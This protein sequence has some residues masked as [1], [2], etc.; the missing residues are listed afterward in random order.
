MTGVQTCALPIFITA[1]LV[2]GETEAHLSAITKTGN[3]PIVEASAPDITVGTMLRVGEALPTTPLVDQ[4]GATT[5]L[6]RLKG[7]RVVLTFIYTRCPD[8]EFCPLMDRN[9]V[10][11]QTALAQTPALADVRLLSISFDPEHDTPE[12]LRAHAQSLK[13]D[14]K[15]WSF[16]APAPADLK[17]FAAKFG[18]TAEPGAANQGAILHNLSTA[19]VAADGTLVKIHP[20]NRW[21]PS[22]ILADLSPVPAPA[23]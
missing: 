6:D 15:R 20:G 7:H 8:P 11:L 17:A 18:V 2:V 22:E 16:A 12:V 4:T 5:S 3:A 13:A 19:V 1:T 10:A 14:P 21:T 23:H 9:F